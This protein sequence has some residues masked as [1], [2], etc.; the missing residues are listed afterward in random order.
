MTYNIIPTYNYYLYRPLDV[1]IQ[2]YRDITLSRPLVISY[3]FNVRIINRYMLLNKICVK[4]YCFPILSQLNI[5]LRKK[6]N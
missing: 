1:D 3:E 6:A 2:T 4:K 5:I